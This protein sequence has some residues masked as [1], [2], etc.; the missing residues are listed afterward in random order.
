MLP[1][2]LNVI[3]HIFSFICRE[4]YTSTRVKNQIQCLKIFWN[5]ITNILKVEKKYHRD[6]WAYQLR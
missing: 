3:I 6:F 4:H 1:I 5:D 2:Y